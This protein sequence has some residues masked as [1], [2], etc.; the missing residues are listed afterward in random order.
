V[1][2]ED[3]FHEQRLGL[4]KRL[5]VRVGDSLGYKNA[6]LRYAPGQIVEEDTSHQF[7]GSA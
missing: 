2:E 6:S 1:I 4:V 7:W 5:S 3:C